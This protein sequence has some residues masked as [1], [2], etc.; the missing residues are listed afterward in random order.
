MDRL[1]YVYLSSSFRFS[2]SSLQMALN[3][4]Q[5]RW[6]L[7]AKDSYINTINTIV[8]KRVLY[9]VLSYI[10]LKI[11]TLHLAQDLYSKRARLDFESCESRSVGGKSL[12]DFACVSSSPNVIENVWG[13]LVVV[14]SKL[15]RNILEYC[16]WL[17]T[18]LMGDTLRSR[19]QSASEWINKFLANC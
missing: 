4:V 13:K 18:R 3:I 7:S 2:P 17:L 10:A 6:Y 16:Q 12:S 15:A 5:N 11:C 1:N 8:S 9:S 14:A 19:E